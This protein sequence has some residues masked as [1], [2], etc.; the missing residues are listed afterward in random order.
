MLP[1][2]LHVGVAKGASTWLYLAYIEH[3]DVWVPPAND[4]VNF[5]LIHNH[6]GL[7]W[8][9]Q[10]YF[11]DYKHEKAVG[12]F[13][14]SYMISEIALERIARDLPGVRLSMLLRNPV[15]RAYLHRAHDHYKIVS[16]KSVDSP[17]ESGDSVDDWNGFIIEKFVKLPLEV[18]M[19]PNGWG[20]CR[21]YLE[22]GLYAAC[23]R[24]IQDRSPAGQVKIMLHEDLC[25]DPEGF[26]RE[27]FHWLG[28]KPDFKPP[29]LRSDVN[30]DTPETDVSRMSP[31]LRDFLRGFYREDTAELQRMLGRDLSHWQ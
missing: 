16:R 23:L 30:P 17:L 14:N 26:I 11:S 1:N 12:E 20:W 25:A 15:E 21:Q 5:L 31:D 19:H 27:Y 8:Y 7:Q 22:P 4:N 24:R 3:P 18:A 6:Y 29:C 13:S 9:Q 10:Q 2:F 28:V